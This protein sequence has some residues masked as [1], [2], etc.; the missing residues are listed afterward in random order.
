MRWRDVLGFYLPATIIALVV[1]FPF[2]WMLSVALR[3]EADVYAYPP[4]LIPRVLAWRNFLRVWTEPSMQIGLQFWNTLVYA[5]VRTFLQL[6]LSSMAA[7]VLARY[8][9][10]F[11]NAIFFIVLAT[12]MIPHEVMIIPLFIMVRHIPL[13]GGNDLFGRGGTGWLNSFPGLILP[14]IVSGYS[15][16]FLRQ[17]FLT[18]APEL[19][20]AARIDGCTELG[21]YWR[22][23]LPTA[24]P[25]LTTLGVFSFQFAWSDFIWPLIITNGDRI[26]T[27]QV[28]LA[29]LSSA[30]GTQ[31][32]LLMASAVIA[33]LPL[34]A[35]F[36]L[37]QRLIVTG[38]SFGVGK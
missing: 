23:C 20:D 31:W 10:P 8:T 5:T 9:L 24:I 12:V 4:H 34:L 26:K 29:V 11:R 3:P 6:L 17:F 15:I 32:S 2:L 14:G 22:I 19:E 33:T 21:V 13:A 27:L 36:V 35:L 18:Q 7:F 1:L 37:L 30:D 25:A 28:G 16:F 38:I